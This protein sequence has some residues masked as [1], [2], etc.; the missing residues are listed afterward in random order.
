MANHNRKSRNDRGIHIALIVLAAV[1]LCISGVFLIYRLFQ[2]K[3]EVMLMKGLAH[4]TGECNA[5]LALI[6]EDFDLNTLSSKIKDAVKIDAVTNVTLPGE[7]TIGIDFTTNYDYRNK[8]MSTD[9][10]FS[11]FRIELAEGSLSADGN[12]VYI[13]LPELLKDNY[14][15]DTDTL[16]KDYQASALPG[17]L[18][19]SIPENTSF[20]LFPDI[21]YDSNSATLVESIGTDL[22]E[23][24]ALLLKNMK[25]EHID[26]VLEIEREG[27]LIKCRGIR[28]V[29]QEDDL[30]TL[31]KDFTLRESVVGNVELYIFFDNQNRIVSISTPENV[32][33]ESA[34][35]VNFS[36]L[37]DGAE[38]ALDHIDGAITY[39][40]GEEENY[41]NMERSAFV[42][43]EKYEN[44]IVMSMSNSH[45]ENERS[46]TYNHTWGLDDRENTMNISVI[47][48][49]NYY[50]CNLINDL[51]VM[52]RGDG[53]IMDIGDLDFLMNGQSLF[54]IFGSIGIRPFEEQVSVPDDG[55]NL[56]GLSEKEID[57]LKADILSSLFRI[58]GGFQ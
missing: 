5:Y 36:F 54:H 51:E 13:V 48:P 53:F 4:M 49:S 27:K 40:N 32:V 25:V 47:T 28:V 17:Y 55:I 15:F 37:F 44:R 56:F 11:I 24:Y 26:S 21:K 22:K 12:R 50:E 38:R 35:E 6:T 52:D 43:E 41:L 1:F 45:K 14:Y 19:Y 18:G 30:N 39:S 42:S 29:L 57:R 10:V 33:F 7:D 2:K 23:D 46:I 31:L 20:S 34:K 3:P 8:K 9:F 16:G 58:Y